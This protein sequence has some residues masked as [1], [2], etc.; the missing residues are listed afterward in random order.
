MLNFDVQTLKSFI[1]K[2][3]YI[4]QVQEEMPTMVGYI[5]STVLVLP[6]ITI[7]KKYILV[8]FVY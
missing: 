4:P 3:Y 5:A 7:L 8:Y 6:I 1:C 2:Q